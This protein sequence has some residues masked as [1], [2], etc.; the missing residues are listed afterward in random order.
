MS[1]FYMSDVYAP[2][3][4]NTTL[5]FPAANLST[6]GLSEYI[7]KK[8]YPV[9][10]QE[11]MRLERL[12]LWGTGR[13]PEVRPLKR[14]TERAVLQR[15]ARTAWLP[16]AISTFAQQMVVDGYRKE[17]DAE[18]YKAAWESW[19]RNKMSMQ[20][21]AIN[22]A[23]MIFGYSFVRVT[24]GAV[25]EG[26]EQGPQKKSMAVMRAVSPMDFFALYEDAYLDEYPKYGFERLPN[27]NYRFWLPKGDYY[28]VTYKDGKFT[29][30]DLVT[31][32][33]G[34]PPFVRYVNQIDLRGRC[35]GD[36]EPVI[37]L[38][39]RIDKTAFDRLMV[40]HFNSFKVR[41]ATGLEQ[42]DTPE[43]VQEDKI[44]IG[45]EDI[46]I[47]SDVQAKFGTLDETQMGG[48]IEAYKADL[49]TFAAVMQLPP[50]LFGQVVNVTGDA[51]DGARRQTYQRLFEKQTVM[52][53]SH[54]QVMRLAA[55]IEGREDD[56][57]DFM[58]RITWQDVE[59]RSL[60]QFADAWGKIVTQLGVPKWAAWSKIPGV[61]QSEVDGWR[62]HALDDDPLS[63]YLREVVGKTTTDLAMDRKTGDP[64]APPVNMEALEMQAKVKAQ[65]P[66]GGNPGNRN[67]KG[68]SNSTQ[69]QRPVNPKT[70]ADRGTATK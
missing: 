70:G 3:E 26:G 59:V 16:L 25:E 32:P 66:G 64:K 41:W 6:K 19:L 45:N 27:G 4:P 52:S 34:V 24:D 62:E 54:G 53:E 33:Y 44:R 8:L 49:E 58:A 31:T 13:Q 28:K 60:A 46:L 1:I 55:L 65:Q 12:E 10:Q 22:R 23:T 40:Q 67:A 35:W 29:V 21:L 9:F 5:E 50:N 69:N 63:N 14:N 36:V 37:D 38:A 2:D 61:E 48:F 47:A 56:A 7:T 11:R 68:G 30:G 43:G 20:Q 57:D 17:G 42:A 39:A 15:M 18:N 51:L